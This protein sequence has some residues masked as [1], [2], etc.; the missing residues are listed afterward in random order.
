MSNHV[1]IERAPCSS[2]SR[3]DDW[4]A[5]IID[6]HF[7]ILNY[8]INEC[9][10]IVFMN[11]MGLNK[12]LKASVRLHTELRLFTIEKVRRCPPVENGHL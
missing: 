12:E 9:K 7:T 1:L 2:F 10:K 3:K 6:L 5:Q 4:L 11:I 8:Y